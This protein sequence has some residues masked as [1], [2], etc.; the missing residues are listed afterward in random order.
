MSLSR[1]SFML[2]NVCH[3]TAGCSSHASRRQYTI[4]SNFEITSNLKEARLPECRLQD[5]VFNKITGSRG[6]R[7]ALVSCFGK[8]SV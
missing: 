1:S 4:Q 5:L 7:I 2:R 8:R 3:R 6:E